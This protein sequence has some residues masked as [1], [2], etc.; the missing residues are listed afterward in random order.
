MSHYRPW[1]YPRVIAHRGGG[2]LAPENTLAGLREGVAR[3][4]RGAE[5]DAMLAAD[6]VPVLIHDETLERT[7]TG[8]GSVTAHTAA[9]LAALDAGRWHSPRFA[10]ERVPTLEA[11]LRYARAAGLWLNIEIKPAKDRAEPTGLAVGLTVARLYADLLQ[12]DGDRANPAESADA[13]VPLFSSFQPQ[14]LAAARAVAPNIPRGLLVS[15]VPP[16]WRAQL[17]ALG[18]VALHTN[19]KNL[20]AAQ[21]HEVKQAGYWLFCYTVDEPARARELFDWGVDAICTD[22]IDLIDPSLATV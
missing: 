2:I 18:A 4:F 13:R 22:R 1:P 12:P 21:A 20:T 16:D 10:G 8:A 7:T 6:G 11:A 17:E 5:F 3:G 9:Q 15:R 14:S 19:H